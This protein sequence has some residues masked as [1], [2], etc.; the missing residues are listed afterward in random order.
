MR[1]PENV[2]STI[3]A[4]LREGNLEE[5]IRD[6][7]SF[8]ERYVNCRAYFPEESPARMRRTEVRPI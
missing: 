7:E 4:A 2:E 8:G 5:A 6:L 3:E 1:L